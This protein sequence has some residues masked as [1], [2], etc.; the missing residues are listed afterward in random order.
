MPVLPFS[1][2]TKSTRITKLIYTF[3]I[4]MLLCNSGYAG[5]KGTE[6]YDSYVEA[7]KQLG[8]NVETSSVEYDAQADV[9]TIKDGKIFIEGKVLNEQNET[10]Q[11]SKSNINEVAFDITQKFDHCQMHGFRYDGNV[12]TAKSLKC[13][14]GVM[15]TVNLLFDKDV[16]GTVYLIQHDSE[17]IDYLNVVPA[18]LLNADKLTLQYHL[19]IFRFLFQHSF[20]K[21]NSSLFQSNIFV[22]LID[23]AEETLIYN[24]RYTYEGMQISDA[25]LGDFG[26]ILVENY[27][28]DQTSPVGWWEIDYGR[29]EYHGVRLSGLLKILEQ[30]DATTN[31]KI[32][33]LSSAIETS[34]KTN[35]ELSAVESARVSVDGV[36]T[37]GWWIT[38]DDFD[39]FQLAYEF[40]V[41]RD[42]AEQKTGFEYLLS[43]SFQFQRNQG[44]DGRTFSGIKI[45]VKNRE[46]KEEVTINVDEAAMRD[47]SSEGFS[48][49]SISGLD[50]QKLP[51]GNTANLEAIAIKDVEFARF[52]TMRPFLVDLSSD[53]DL[54]FS[55]PFAAGRAFA[56][57]SMTF[58]V[59]GFELYEPEFG[60]TRTGYA[61]ASFKSSIP[62]I[63]TSVSFRYEDL[64]IPVAR[65]ANHDIQNILNGLGYSDLTMSHRAQLVWDQETLDL[66][67]DQMELKIDGL[68]KVA[69]T[70]RIASF[71]KILFEDPLNQFEVAVVSA[72]IADASLLYSDA[73]LVSEKLSRISAEQNLPKD[74]L[75][76]V[77][78][79]QAAQATA[80]IQNEAFTKMVSDAVS[81][82]LNDP[83]ELKVTLSPANPIP[84]AQILGSMAA[85]QTLPDLLNVKI[86]AN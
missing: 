27:T 28:Y 35:I 69:A 14:D 75:H 38:L 16:R 30:N 34:L 11:S 74:L 54:I 23:F 6:A 68:G 3:S 85:P 50:I 81:T 21:Q 7:L 45:D 42:W 86:E 25:V 58:E 46:L 22:N 40:F 24:E 56:P 62:P 82:Y 55:K 8:F 63:P 59:R 19:P 65:I 60:Y 9:L 13:I 2:C 51:E 15:L 80:P 33:L 67:V 39:L 31:Q 41:P 10:L 83:K 70:A 73:G 57:T 84:L 20:T 43:E 53:P 18:R 32:L 76:D 78:V 17:T 44:F 48:E 72:Q 12:I 36:R 29:S 47:L 77:V 4:L 26:S 52:S 1:L 71:P 37:D 5:N 49:F 79:A 66:S 64:Q 61:E